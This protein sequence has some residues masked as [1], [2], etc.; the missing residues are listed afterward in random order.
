MEGPNAAQDLGYQANRLARLLRSAISNQVAPLGLT[1]RQAAVVLQLADAGQLTMSDLAERIGIDRPTLTG[2]I[3][4]LI[5]DGWLAS[6]VNPDDRRSR[7]VALTD[8][9]VEK[10]PQLG[11]AAAHATAPALEALGPDDAAALLSLLNR[12]SA[13]IGASLA[14]VRETC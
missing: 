9:A 3:D 6:V 4:R 12:A 14:D 10:V 7:L 13:A 11:A 8:A 1:S 5:R 2:V